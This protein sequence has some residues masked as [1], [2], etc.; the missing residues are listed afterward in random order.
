M[1]P[2]PVFVGYDSR[3]EIGTHVFNASVLE[4]TTCP[5]SITMLNK[6]VIERLSGG[7]FKNGSNA[8]TVLRFLV[9]WLMDFKGIALFC[10][11]ADMVAAGDLCELMDLLDLTKA[12][13]VVKHD[14]KTKYPRKYLGTSLECDNLDYERKQWASVML[15]NCSHSAWRKVG[16]LFVQNMPALELLQLRFL[17]DSAIGALPYEWNWLADEMGSNREAKIIHYTAGIPAFER[18]ANVPMAY[19]WLYYRNQVNHS[20]K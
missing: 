2:L 10:D 1:K 4:N 17:E 12:V 11:G 8:F 6:G 20:V 13:Q 19:S 7:I 14:Y 3:E 9:P 15:F 5:V 18:H 16:P